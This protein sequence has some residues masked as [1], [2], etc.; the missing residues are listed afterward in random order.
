MQ[1]LL[2]GGLI[3]QFV[4]GHPVPLGGPVSGH[5]HWLCCVTVIWFILQMIDHLPFD[6]LIH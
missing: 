3:S 4:P 2:E 1:G 5:N 6:K